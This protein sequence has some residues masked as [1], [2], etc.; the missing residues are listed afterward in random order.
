VGEAQVNLLNAKAAI[1]K[2]TI[3]GHI[4]YTIECG[5]QYIKNTSNEQAEF[6]Q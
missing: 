3:E 2:T 4:S 1:Q 5:E 6:N